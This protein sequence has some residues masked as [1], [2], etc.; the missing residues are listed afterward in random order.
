MS[1]EMKAYMHSDKMKNKVIGNLVCG[2]IM[3]GVMAGLYGWF[4]FPNSNLDL[5]KLWEVRTAEYETYEPE[6]FETAFPT[7]KDKMGFW[8]EGMCFYTPTTVDG[9]ENQ[10]PEFTY[11][12]NNSNQRCLTIE[13]SMGLFIWFILSL[14]NVVFAMAVLFAYKSHSDR[15]FKFFNSLMS[16]SGCVGFVVFILLSCSRWS[17][18]GRACSGEFMTDEAQ[19]QFKEFYDA[20]VEGGAEAC[21]EDFTDAEGAVISTNYYAPT[22]ATGAF[23]QII[24]I[25]S[26]S[27]IG[28]VCCCCVCACC[29]MGMMGKKKCEM[30]ADAT[31]DARGAQVLQ[32]DVSASANVSASNM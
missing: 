29:C 19:P 10:V 25:I 13:F 16:C 12:P 9:I 6:A 15:C 8:T 14:C 17:E 22:L 28:L 2:I 24:L 31:A 26:W 20:C 23:L 7:H 18:A 11:N 30:A 5:W 27:V 1:S 3:N 21:K 32:T 4:V